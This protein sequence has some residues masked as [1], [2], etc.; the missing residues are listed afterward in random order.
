MSESQYFTTQFGE[1]IKLIPGYGDKT[2]FNK[3]AGLEGKKLD[4][5]YKRLHYVE[6]SKINIEI[7]NFGRDVITYALLMDYLDALGLLPEEGYGRGIDIGGREGIHAAL[8]RAHHAKHMIS[9]D[10]MDGNDP[11]LNQKMKKIFVN[12]RKHQ[13]GEYFLKDNPITGSILQKLFPGKK[14]RRFMT[15]CGDVPSKK[16]FYDFN[17]KREAVVDEFLV[18]DILKQETRKVDI[19]LCF[20]AL[21]LIDYKQL[22]AKVAEMLPSGG[23]FAFFER[24]TWG[25]GPV[26]GLS[27][28]FPYFEKRLTLADIKKY[29]EQYKPGELEYVEKLYNLHDPKRTSLQQYIDQSYDVGMHLVGF[30]PMLVP[31]LSDTI[32]ESYKPGDAVVRDIDANEVLR[33]IH[34]FRPEIEKLDLQTSYFMMVFKKF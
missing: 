16:H 6:G 30:K 31:F 23:V 26:S 34:H 15:M 25:P 4:E 2:G 20:L 3:K 19:A 33:D 29:Y 27:G 28:D 21:C 7:D 1:K 8:F 22:I 5:V 32:D 14:S 11:E 24:Y 10:L 13:I 17:L 18:G 9:A 12:Q